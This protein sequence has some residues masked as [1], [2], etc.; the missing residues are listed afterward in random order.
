MQ[1]VVQE[2]TYTV[3]VLDFAQANVSR[4]LRNFRGLSVRYSFL[5][6]E[7]KCNFIEKKVLTCCFETSFKMFNITNVFLFTVSLGW[8]LIVL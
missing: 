4:A 1:A 5:I 7:H 8:E 2:I 3:V 6:V